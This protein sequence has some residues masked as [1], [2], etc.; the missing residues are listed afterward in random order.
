MIFYYAEYPV[1]FNRGLSTERITYAKTEF[2]ANRSDVE[3]FQAN[4]SEA[5]IF[6]VE[7]SEDDAYRMLE[8]G[9]I[10]ASE[11]AAALC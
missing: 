7:V 3:K 1:T 10:G 9:E 6:S 4:N 2:M 8:D 5:K 11:Y